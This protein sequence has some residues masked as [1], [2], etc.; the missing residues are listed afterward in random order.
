LPAE[1]RPVGAAVIRALRPSLVLLVR[2]GRQLRPSIPGYG[3]AGRTAH[4]VAMDI[5]CFA[6]V[7]VGRTSAASSSSMVSWY[8]VRV[9]TRGRSATCPAAPTPQGCAMALRDRGVSLRPRRQPRIL[10]FSW[11]FDTESNAHTPSA[12]SGPRRLRF[13][14][15]VIGQR[16]RHR[17]I[18]RRGDES[19]ATRVIMLGTAM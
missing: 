2:I 19:D 3:C 10:S 14:A 4:G 15:A 9:V 8:V 7:T 6:F 13:G 1:R 16:A 12:L 11:A 5:R 18:A 17:R